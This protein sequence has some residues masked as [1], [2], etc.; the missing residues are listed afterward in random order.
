MKSTPELHRHIISVFLILFF[1][2]PAGLQ[3]AESIDLNQA[4]G[5]ALARNPSLAA[6]RSEVDAARA[7][8][9]Q[10]KAVYYPQVR[11]SAGYDRTGVDLESTDGGTVTTGN[12]AAGVS[13]SQYLFDFGKSPAEVE[14]TRQALRV[15]EKDLTTVEKTLVRDMEQAYFEVL[16]NQ[17][18]VAVSQENLEV[19]QQLL[20]QARAHYDQ[21]MRPR[22]DVTR[23]E[24]EVS[25]ARLDL[26]TSRFGLQEATIA[27]ERLLGGPPVSGAYE[28]TDPA[29]GTAP[30]ADLNRLLQLALAERS[31]IAA[32]EAQI[33]A[34]QASSLVARRSAYPSLNASGS[35]T[36][37]GE[38][39][40]MEDHRWQAGVSLD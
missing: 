11:A 36:Y 32:L 25:Q 31:E 21:G 34:A 13:V 24:A 38:E 9:T 35:Y 15:S 7:G 12:Y 19:R 8:V 33:A 27:L 30:L 18:L 26:V 10:A 4:L 2:F 29:Q 40:P 23:A 17:Q 22:I 5:I 16:K 28:L 20:D 14:K 39:V 6:S 37:D 3:A 1:M